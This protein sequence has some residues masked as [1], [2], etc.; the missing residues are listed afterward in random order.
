MIASLKGTI[1]QK[2]EHAIA[3]DVGGVGYEV[4]IPSNELVKLKPGDELLVFTYLSVSERALDLYGSA[5]EKVIAWFKMLLN[6]KGV[7]P[8]SALA[9]ISKANPE[10]LSAALQAESADILV[11][12]GINKKAAERIVLEL[13][14][15]AKDLIDVKD[16]ATSASVTLDSEAI[17]ALEA[18]GYSREQARDAL[19]QTEGD[20]VETKIRSALQVLGK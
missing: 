1:L 6:V 2:K 7:G 16:R 20:D 10:D 11:N 19:K 18:L 8:K 4:A 14:N 17:Q 12:C 15:K 3:L 9:I 5:D 13:K